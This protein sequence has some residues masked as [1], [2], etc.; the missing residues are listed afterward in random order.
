[1]FDIGATE[2]LI[3]AIVAIIVVGPKDL[4]NLL[5]HIGHIISYGKKLTSDLKGQINE[6]VEETGV[7]DI[8]KTVEEAAQVDTSLMEDID[9][10]FFSDDAFGDF[11]EDV[12]EAPPEKPVKKAKPAVKA[13]K[14]AGK[15]PPAGQKP[16]RRKTTQSKKPRNKQKTNKA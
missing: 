14:T 9:D 7:K 5:R 16:R 6:A 11:G 1:M 4:P 10:E 13:K 3:L 2:L 8:Q 15:K 12:A